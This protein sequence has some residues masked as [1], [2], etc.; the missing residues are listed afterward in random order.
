LQ[1]P[2]LKTFMDEVRSRIIKS[3]QTE[4]SNQAFFDIVIRNPEI[5]DISML[6]SLVVDI[7]KNNFLQQRMKIIFKNFVQ[8]SVFT[9][10]S[11]LLRTFKKMLSFNF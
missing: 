5:V 7:K 8:H 2:I 3:F 1:K 6:E 4:S 9:N 11:E 10:R